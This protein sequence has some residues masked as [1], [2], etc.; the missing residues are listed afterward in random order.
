MLGLEGT[1]LSPEEMEILKHPLV[2]GVILFSRNYQSPEQLTQL[3]EAVHEL[4]QPRL[5][6]AVDQEGGRVQRLQTGFTR[7]PPVRLLGEVYDRDPGRARRLA[8]ISGWLMATELRAVGVDFSFAPVL[9]L[10]RGISS[11]IGDRAFHGDPTVVSKLAQAY[12]EGMQKAGME[13]VGK[14]FPGHG[15]VAA[16]SHLALPVDDRPYAD[17]AA[18]DMIPFQRMMHAGLAGIMPAH[19]VYPQVD[20]QPAGFSPLWL[21][22]IIRQQLGFQGAVFSDDLDMA[23]AAAAGPP[24]ERARAALVAGCDMVLAC[25]DRPA[26]LAILSGLEDPADPTAHLRLVRLHGRNRLNPARLRENEAWQQAVRFVHD[27][28][29][30]PLL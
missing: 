1:T 18:N 24:V 13:A 27:Q 15:G 7:L 6:V 28:D 5:L 10:D 30:F 8:R 12:M 21:K 17:I 29:A 11:V 26:A 25:N 23:G 14:H 16:D 22:Q 3:T 4:R 20:E 19:V 2:G 9:D